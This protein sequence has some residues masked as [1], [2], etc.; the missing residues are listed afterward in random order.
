MGDTDAG[1]K[2]DL[3]HHTTD[4]DYDDY[5]RDQRIKDATRPSLHLSVLSFVIGL[6]GMVCL[7]IFLGW[8]YGL[9]GLG[10]GI[11]AYF[12]ARFLVLQPMLG[13][14]FLAD[15]QRRMEKLDAID[16]ERDR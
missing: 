2:G 8:Q 14:L 3:L 12:L 16:A 9:W 1:Q 6:P 5:F 11:P 13:A 10:I 15:L 4:A 7:S